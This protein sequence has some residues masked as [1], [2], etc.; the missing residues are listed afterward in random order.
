MKLLGFR[1]FLTLMLA[2]AGVTLLV[3]Q[4]AEPV[5][6]IQLNSD[7]V[8]TL[9]NKTL[10]STNTFNG[11]LGTVTGGIYNALTANSIPLLNGSKALTSTANPTNG[12]LLIGSTGAIPALG[13]L[14][15]TANQLTVTPGAGSITLSTPQNIHTGASPTFA[16]L[17]LS[18]PLTVGNGGIGTN[19]TP[20]N[21]Q[22]P[23][24]NGTGFTLAALTGTA[25]RVTVTNGA[26]TITLNGPQDLHSG[27]SPTFAGSTF[28]GAVAFQGAVTSSKACA[29]NYTRLTT[30][31]CQRNSRTLVGW[32]DATACTAR[33]TGDSLGSGS[34]V[35]L[36]LLW[37]VLANNGIANRT[38]F[39]N[40]YDDA[41]CAVTLR[42]VSNVQ[43]QEFAAT[44]AGTIILTVQDLVSIKLQG[45]DT[46]YATQ[47]NAGGNGNGDLSSFY[48]VGYY[49]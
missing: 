2:T 24:G 28:T 9:S 41:A 22:L 25:N 10:D 1:F 21:G 37:T 14:T 16:G 46:F 4:F 33:T 45:T 38:N 40:F 18:S 5:T 27:A 12:Q 49:D 26:G 36:K 30:N 47:G 39:A 42:E 13:S 31:Y 6:K 44:A 48:V 11:T 35:V 34:V 32:T 7:S 15:G 3:A 29:A 17:T 43:A 23:I 8:Q 20:T 19:G